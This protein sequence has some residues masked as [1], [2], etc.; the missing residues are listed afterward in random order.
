MFCP[1]SGAQKKVS[2]HGLIWEQGRDFLKRATQSQKKEQN[3]GK[4]EQKWIKTY[5]K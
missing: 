2:A 4:T 5:Q 1:P 3:K